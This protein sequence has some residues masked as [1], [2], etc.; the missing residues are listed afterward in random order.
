MLV[1]AFSSF[2]FSLLV[3]PLLIRLFA[4]GGRYSGNIPFTSYDQ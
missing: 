2:I 1:L 3:D 4:M